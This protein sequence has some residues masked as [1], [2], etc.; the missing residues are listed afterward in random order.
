MGNL[1]SIMP[2]PLN[3]SFKQSDM[4]NSI[5]SMG[6]LRKGGPQSNTLQDDDS[7]EGDED[8]EEDEEDENDMKPM[9]IEEFRARVMGMK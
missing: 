7:K 6:A 5:T 1:G 2:Q 9:G 3:P 8:D 4:V